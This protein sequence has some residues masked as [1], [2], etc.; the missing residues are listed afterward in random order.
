MWAIESL[1][2]KVKKLKSFKMELEYILEHH[3]IP[4]F[5]NPIGFLRARACTV[6]DHYCSIDFVNKQNITLAVQ[7]ISKCILDKDLP[8]KVKAAVAL[9]S[10]LKHKEAF[11]LINTSLP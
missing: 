1:S 11:D 6:F 7:G 2:H 5:D 10:V 8:V 9:S 3:I 4:E